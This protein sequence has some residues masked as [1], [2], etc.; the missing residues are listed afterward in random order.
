[1]N[2]VTVTCNRDFQHMLL[3]AESIQKFVEP[4]THWIVINEY[5]NLNVDKWHD[6]LSKIY[7]DHKYNILTPTDFGISIL[8]TSGWH[9][10]QYFKLA[11]STFT[12]AD[13]IIVDT[14]VF[15]IKPTTLDYWKNSMGNGILYKFRESIEG[16][17]WVDNWKDIST[18]YAKKF[19]ATPLTH[20]LFSPPFKIDI[21]I[22]KTY[23]MKNLLS[24]LYPTKEEEKSYFELNGKQLYPSEFIFYSYLARDYFDR[25]VPVEHSV[26]SIY[27]IHLKDKNETQILQEILQKMTLA[28]VNNNITCFSIHPLIFNRL[29]DHQINLI[30]KWLTKKGFNFQFSPKIL[31]F[32]L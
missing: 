5:E 20:F 14:K 29:S 10:Q 6:A 18:Y 24:D 23:D 21:D 9:T 22:I 15:F 32:G 16:P 28:D 17:S 25:H 1:M 7:S 26:L 4:C 12:N 3:Q 11:I 19:N 30:N 31:T 13:Y 27:P 2:L 8:P